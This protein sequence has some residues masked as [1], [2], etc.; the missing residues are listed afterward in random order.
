M[1][2][3][4]E[5]FESWGWRLFVDNFALLLDFRLILHC[6][7]VQRA[8]LMGPFNCVCIDFS[9][10]NSM[11]DV[12]SCVAKI[13]PLDYCEKVVSIDLSRNQSINGII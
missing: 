2:F 13:Q 11:H 7:I 1:T 6:N 12:K 9:Y 3:S 4:T 10:F 8:L 5:D